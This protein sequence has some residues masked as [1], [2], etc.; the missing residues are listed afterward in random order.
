MALIPFD[1]NHHDNQYFQALK[2][3][4]SPYMGKEIFPEEL[5]TT[6]RFVAKG[7]TPIQD[8]FNVEILVAVAHW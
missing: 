4:A 8:S 7:E 3:Q 2:G 5:A 1:S 6:I